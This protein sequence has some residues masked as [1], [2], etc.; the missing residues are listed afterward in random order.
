M[1][2]V[3]Q[4]MPPKLMLIMRNLNTIRAIIK[5]HASGVERYRE[6]ARVAV[7]GRYSGGLRGTLA[8]VVFDLRL[9]LDWVRSNVM[10]VGIR[11]ATSLG[12]IPDILEEV[13]QL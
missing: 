11:L 7:S 13:D 3:F 4:K 6:M 8:R 10:R 9:T 2:D 5:D 12:Y 1:L